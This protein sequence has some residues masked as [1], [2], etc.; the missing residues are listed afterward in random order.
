MDKRYK[1]LSPAEELQIRQALLEELAAD[2]GRP[3]PAVIKTIRCRLRFTIPEYAAICGVSA[4]TLQD[5]EREVASPCLHTVE[6]L[7]HPVGMQLAV[8]RRGE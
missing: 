6:K 2:P 5:I 4:R 8:I 7:L 3:V 1:P